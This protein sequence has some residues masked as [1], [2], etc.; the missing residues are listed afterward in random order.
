MTSIV[1]CSF[2][3][4]NFFATGKTFLVLGLQKSQKNV[5][6]FRANIFG[7]QSKRTVKKG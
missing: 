2:I 6:R 5:R 7:T 3:F 1:D 4:L